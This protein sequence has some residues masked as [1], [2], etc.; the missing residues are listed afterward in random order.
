MQAINKARANYDIYLFA[1]DIIPS[2]VRSSYSESLSKLAPA[3]TSFLGIKKFLKKSHTIKKVLALKNSLVDYFQQTK[4]KT[5]RQQFWE[6]YTTSSIG[7][8]LAGV[9]GF[10][11][12]TPIMQDYIVYST[13]Y[14]CWSP[15][16]KKAYEHFSGDIQKMI[17]HASKLQSKIRLILLP[18]GFSF[19]DE[20]Y[21]GREH[22][23]F[24]IPTNKFVSLVGLRNKLTS[25]FTN[26]F[27][28]VEVPLRRQINTD[29]A[30][31]ENKCSNLFYYAYDGHLNERGHKFL[32]DQLY[33]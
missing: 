14:E 6:N 15:I 23:P 13:P 21:P 2:D 11:S 20:N 26:E 5:A 31:C 18:P 25:D 10:D 1:N 19:T 8:C 4:S 17:S 27:I 24:A 3:K 33:K 12:F 22:Q 9:E 16:H 28:D 30:K 7:N 29:R 32:Y